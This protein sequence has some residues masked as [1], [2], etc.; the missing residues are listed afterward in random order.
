MSFSQFSYPYSFG[1]F[2]LL[3]FT[4]GFVL[5]IHKNLTKWQINAAKGS[6][7]STFLYLLF[8]LLFEIALLLQVNPMKRNTSIYCKLTIFLRAIGSIGSVYFS[9]LFFIYRIKIILS[10]ISS[11]RCCSIVYCKV[12]N[13]MWHIIIIA[14][15]AL[16][17]YDS[18]DVYPIT[19]IINNIEICNLE[20][21]LVIYAGFLGALFSLIV[22]CTFIFITYKICHTSPTI[23]RRIMRTIFAATFVTLRYAFIPFYNLF[24]EYNRYWIRTI[25]VLLNAVAILSDYYHYKFAEN[26]NVSPINIDKKKDIKKDKSAT[27]KDPAINIVISTELTMCSSSQG[28]ETDNKM[29]TILNDAID[30]GFTGKNIEPQIAFAIQRFWMNYYIKLNIETKN[31]LDQHI[32]DI[33]TSD[34]QLPDH[35]KSKPF[36]FLQHLNK[37]FINLL[38]V[39]IDLEYKLRNSWGKLHKALNISTSHCE[40]ILQCINKTLLNH[41]GRDIYNIEMKYLFSRIYRLSVTMMF[42]TNAEGFICKMCNLKQET[43]ELI[44][45]SLDN[46]MQNEIGKNLIH[47]YLRDL[48]PSIYLFYQLWWK[49][50][51]INS[52]HC[53]SEQKYS[54]LT[55]VYKTLVKEFVMFPIRISTDLRTELLDVIQMKANERYDTVINELQIFQK[56]IIQK[57]YWN[58]FSLFIS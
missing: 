45:I 56:E 5:Y 22:L 43:K 35:Y 10:R 13:I 21:N 51:A 15:L 58:T 49:F 3:L 47:C 14:V 34:I 33:M 30:N 6:I 32:N 50:N 18:S 40:T 54:F 31:R 11:S 19:V 38:R 44:I 37:L 1:V 42:E 9:Q 28:I 57:K 48:N 52:D 27:L 4:I 53:T 55:D 2:V 16:Y 39:D 36:P 24:S 23:R 12:L 29:E 26:I 17:M 25:S 20:L 46:C 8:T 7:I 41:F